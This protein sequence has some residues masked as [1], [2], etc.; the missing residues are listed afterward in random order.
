MALC[1]RLDGGESVNR[2]QDRRARADFTVKEQ[3]ALARNQ[4]A[5]QGLDGAMCMVV[6]RESQCGK[7][8]FQARLRSV[9]YLRTAEGFSGQPAGLI[10][11]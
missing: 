7:I 3:R 8:R 2:R 10:A 5:C 1:Q 6:R 4:I 11:F 9:P